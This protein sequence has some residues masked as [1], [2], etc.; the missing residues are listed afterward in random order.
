MESPPYLGDKITESIAQIS[1]GIFGIMTIGFLGIFLGPISSITA[2]FGGT[3]CYSIT[4]ISTWISS[5]I[6]THFSITMPFYV[7]HA[8]KGVSLI[9]TA[10]STFKFRQYLENTW[11]TKIKDENIEDE[12]KN[13]NTN[14]NE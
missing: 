14:E 13:I 12:T 5:S 3:L 6:A 2:I 11:I 9:I 10:I 1:V 4:W 8:L 7:G